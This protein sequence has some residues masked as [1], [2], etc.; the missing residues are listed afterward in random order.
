[1]EGSDQH[2][3]RA[4]FWFCFNRH[5]SQQGCKKANG[6]W[7]LAKSKPKDLH[8]RGRREAQRKTLFCHR[9][10]QMNADFKKQNEKLRKPEIRNRKKTKTA[11]LPG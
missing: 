2:S 11:D 7:Q 6:N 3:A 1:V 4:P 9:F 8:H 5:P 10:A